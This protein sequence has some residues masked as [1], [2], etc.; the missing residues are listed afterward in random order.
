M[1]SND[2]K[3]IEGNLHGASVRLAASPSANAAETLLYA[4]EAGFLEG[5]TRSDAL[6]NLDSYLL[7]YVKFGEGKLIYDQDEYLL[8]G[9]SIFL[10]NCKNFFQYYSTSKN[11]WTVLYLYFNGIQ[12]RGY[13]NMM[14]KIKL[15]IDEVS[16]QEQFLA[17]FWQIIDLHRKKNKYAELLTS[18]HI[19]RML[20]E[21]CMFGDEKMVLEVEYPDYIRK[22]FHHI[23]HFYDEKITYEILSDLYSVNKYH[24][25]K[26]FKHYAGTTI[27]EYIITTRINKA[28]ELLHYTEKT[29]EE[30][31]NE[32]G[33]YSAG[34]F[35][36]LFRKREHTTPLSYRK[37]WTR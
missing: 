21:L 8:K 13:Y 27:S 18:L 37:Q 14:P 23:D 28:K 22:V 31:A 20:T 24:L 17:R 29:I 25:A 10:I 11:G 32:L 15:Q 2:R 33:F 5:S 3:N 1:I 36:K 12:A 6:D 16:S 4:Q 26:E 35:I 34:H 9:G 7:L 30:I 19:T